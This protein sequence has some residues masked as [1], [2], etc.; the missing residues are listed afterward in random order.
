MQNYKSGIFSNC[1]THLN[2]GLLLVGMTD[3]YWLLK[4]SWEPHGVKMD[5]LDFKEE[6]HVEFVKQL[7]TQIFIFDYYQRY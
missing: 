7:I 6:I 2:L 5:I 3:S 4:N 1:F